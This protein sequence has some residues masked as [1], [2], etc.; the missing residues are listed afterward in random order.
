MDAA[1]VSIIKDVAILLRKSRGLEEDLEKHKKDLIEMCE[2]NNWRYTVYEEISSSQKFEER[3]DLMRLIEDIENGEYDAIAVMDK[4]RLSREGVGQATLNK[5]LAENECL[6]ITPQK[7]YDLNDESDILMSEVQ[8]LMARFEYRQI[9]KRFKRGKRRGAKDGHWTNG[10]PPIPYIYNSETKSLNI[11]N[12]KLDIYRF[13]IDEFLNGNSPY[14]ITWE[15]NKMKIPSPRGG[16][17]KDI[18]VRRLLLDET[19]LGRIISNKTGKWKRSKGSASYISNRREDWIIRENCH[20]AVKTL[21]EHEKILIE[22]NKRKRVTYA[23]SGTFSLTGLV[24]CIKCNKSMSFKRKENDYPMI[25]KCQY[26]LND[27]VTRCDNGG[28][29]SK[30]LVE[31]IHRQ[32]C[33]YKEDIEKEIKR[34][35]NIK[36]LDSTIQREIT[37][38]ENLIT[39]LDNELEQVTV[40]ALAKFFSPQEAVKQ[41]EKILKEIERLENE[42]YTLNVQNQNFDNMTNLDRIKAIEHV[43]EITND[44]TV[45]DYAKNRAYKSII[46]SI[47]WDRK[48]DDEVSITVNFL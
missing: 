7:I 31:E 3:P 47:I 41:K 11:D 10:I 38:K 27:G 32:L 29:S 4:D 23:K 22:L 35:K 46:H 43:L 48:S 20:K 14:N 33:K 15:L 25:K 9:T 1:I 13:I 2:E 16:L 12:D 21:N 18:T 42:I 6:I 19:H 45:S 5:I 17:W 44:D 36:G 34:Q 24:K 28:G 8:D 40:L 39:K 37:K 26:F 30:I